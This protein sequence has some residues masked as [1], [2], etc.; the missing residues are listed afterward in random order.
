MPIELSQL[1]EG[2]PEEVATQAIAQIN[3]NATRL[4]AK[5]FIDGDDRH[6][7]PSVRLAEVVSERDALKE[8]VESQSTQLESL[9][10]LTTDNAEAQ[11]TI[12]TLQDNLNSA[13]QLS[14]NAAITAA[15]AEAL[16]NPDTKVKSV[17]PVKDLLGFIDV[18]SLTVKEDGTV[19]DI[20]TK[21]TELQAAKPYLF[22]ATEEKAKGS[23][24]TGNPGNPFGGL[25]L[26]HDTNTQVG[27]FGKLLAQ[28][29][30]PAQ[31]ADPYFKEGGN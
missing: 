8:T 16:A 22:S 18:E 27:T 24:G 10:S 28:Q 19:P 4:D 29:V 2:L 14:K 20:S 12:Q 23:N 25:D 6:Y 15:V 3:T 7:V 21:L 5:V 11:T 1:L 26:G 13:R 9:S 31:Q 30:A 17:A